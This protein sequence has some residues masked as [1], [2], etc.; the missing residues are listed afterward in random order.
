MPRKKIENL[1]IKKHMFTSQCL[2][3][4]NLINSIDD[5]FD[6]KQ[7]ISI[8]EPDFKFNEMNLNSKKNLDIQISSI[9]HTGKK[10]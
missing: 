7:S 1:E 4:S 9:P 3:L 6:L 8:N 2:K 10:E 5:K